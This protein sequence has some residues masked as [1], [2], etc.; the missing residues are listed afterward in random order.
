MAQWSLFVNLFFLL[1]TT[2]KNFNLAVTK[3]LQKKFF[4]HMCD[5]FY[6]KYEY[7]WQVWTHVTNLT[8][9]DN[10]DHMWQLRPQATTYDKYDIM[11]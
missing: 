11:S 4:N 5:M 8:T 10:S 7:M 6:H 1:Y 2:S 3:L 9:C